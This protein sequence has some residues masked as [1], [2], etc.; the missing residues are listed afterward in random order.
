MNY[1]HHYLSPSNNKKATATFTRYLL[2]ATIV[3]LTLF[4]C[5]A[6]RMHKEGIELMNQGQIEE[7]LD[8]LKEAI[9]N[10]PDNLTFRADLI[11]KR[12]LIVHSL[13][14]EAGNERAAGHPDQAS[15][16]YKRVQKID[17]ENP[18]AKAG[19][20]QLNMDVRHIDALKQARDLFDKHD[21]EG[22]QGIIR[23]I[24]FENPEH[25]ETKQ[26]QRK[27]HEQIAKEAMAAPTLKPELKKPVTLQFRDANLKMVVE[28][29][30]RSSGV[31]I[32]LDKDVKTDLK[33]TIFVNDASIEDTL[34]LIL[35]Q[36]QLE[37]K[38][39]SDNTVF[40]YPNNPAKLK[41]HQD[42][43]IRSF[44]LVNADAKQMQ[45][46]LKTILK[47]RDLFV[48][49]KTNSVVIRDTPDAI[50]LAEKLIAGQDLAEAEV[51]LEV[52]IIELSHN[53]LNEL[54]IKLPQQIAVTAPGTPA[55]S[56][57]I[58]TSG[59]SVITTNTPAAPLTLR[60][61]RNLN[62][63]YFNVSP[64]NASLDLR[65]ED[66][67]ANILASP[68]IR[69]RHKEKAK[70]MIGDRVPVITSAQTPITGGAVSTTNVQYLDVG[71]K[72]EVEPDI[73]L[74]EDVAIKVNLEVSNIV[75]EITSGQT[76]A[77][78][79]GSRSATTVLRLKD[80]ETQV[81]AGLISDEDRNSAQKFPGLGDLPIL[82]RLFSSHRDDSR[83]TEIV[84]SITPR[85]TR[86]SQRPDAQNVEFWSG[87]D[88]TLRSKPL[89]LKPSNLPRRLS[90]KVDASSA[91]AADDGGNTAPRQRR[92]PNRADESVVTP[93][94][95][96]TPAPAVKG[97]DDSVTPNGTPISLNWQAPTQA[98]V[99]KEFDVTLEAQTSQSLSTMSFTL[100]Y[101]SAALTIVK[102]N[103]GELLKQNGKK[104]I[105]TN[106][107]DQAGGHIVA[108]ISRVGSE[109]ATGK[110]SIATFTFAP[111]VG[112]SQSSIMITNPAPVNS[113]GQ[114][115]PL[116]PPAPL[117]ITLNP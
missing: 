42:L 96:T 25:I 39:L 109:G 30:S 81:L 63:S 26:L 1:Q 67:S 89:T 8:K 59:G 101:D 14:I 57:S 105:F 115:L 86:T 69:V 97:I 24:L 33:T 6:D 41:E 55:T 53:R 13:L 28:A 19:L 7:G 72:L 56:S 112:K 70:I 48:D 27:I 16:I 61:L 90:S 12:D 114:A 83:K 23:S 10:D 108:Q 71:L 85:L 107:V 17:S 36:T 110:G 87:T 80:G 21:L 68:R 65:S 104:T 106:K 58:T 95:I 4:G 66:G 93:A 79:I 116:T 103:E 76:I 35:L 52:E 50:R 38:I 46:M 15:A 51:V 60:T 34:D 78:Q 74:D 31:N 73:H 32:I 22:A 9:K 3:S 29:L 64:L 49:E 77:Y 88:S 98:T 2:A 18:R 5:A 40:I 111:R 113:D 11:Q 45:L 92:T 43:K 99:G 44:H 20:A 62:G 102:V 94:P 75:R 91:A 82:G 84:M 100:D 54:G 117:V 47:T 37:K